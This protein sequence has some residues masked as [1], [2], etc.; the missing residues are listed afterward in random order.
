MTSIILSADF[1]ARQRALVAGFREMTVLV[2]EDPV[3]ER[4]SNQAVCKEDR[5]GVA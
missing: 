1:E 2:R 4:D 3:L 5:C